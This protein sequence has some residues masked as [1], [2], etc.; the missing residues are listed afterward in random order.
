MVS[1]AAKR[2]R[3]KKLAH[4]RQE[5]ELIRPTRQMDP[6]DLTDPETEQADDE[7]RFAP[8]GQSVEQMPATP[9]TARAATECDYDVVNMIKTL[10]GAIAAIAR[11]TA[12]IQR[13]YKQLRS[14]NVARDKALTDLSNIVREFGL[15]PINRRPQ[16][17]LR[18]DVMDR[19]GNLRGADIGITWEDNE[20]F[21]HGVRV[22]GPDPSRRP[23]M[24]PAMSTPH[25]PM[26]GRNRDDL[27]STVHQQTRPVMST[28]YQPTLG[29]D[30]DDSPSTVHQQTRPVMSTPYQPT[31]GQDRDLGSSSVRPVTPEVDYQMRRPPTETRQGYRPAAPIQ[32]FNNKSLNWPAWFRHFR[33]VA[34]VHGWNKDQRALQLVSYLD[35]T[36]MNVAQELGD[37]DLYNYDVLVKL[38]S[39]RFDPASRV[40]ASR[41]R[42]HG[43]SCRH[44]EDADTFADALAE[45][46]R[47]GYPQSPAELRQELIAEQFVRGQS[48][49]ELKKYLW[50]VIRTQKDRKLQTLIEVC[51]DFSS[52]ST[53]SHLHSVLCRRMSPPTN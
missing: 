5:R 40:S 19:D 7:I 32:R 42:F 8:R 53:S 51:T 52:L 21:L 20:T 43:R 38:L 18:E 33:A 6:A 15:S 49:P 47:V 9:A 27:P 17:A 2:A 45:L 50:V 10:N 36:A 31:L 11:D 30:R 29:Q 1:S 25:Q 44:H 26:G 23:S 3:K 4:E 14:E 39:D 28:P 16:P 46:C 35:E 37:A 41:S 12:S 48:D 24:R 22:V 34:D 13:A